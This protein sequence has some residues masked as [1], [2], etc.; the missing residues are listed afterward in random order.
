MASLFASVTSISSTQVNKALLTWQELLAESFKSR[1]F[2]LQ[3]FPASH[4][5]CWFRG[6]RTVGKWGG[7][8]DSQPAR[9]HLLLYLFSVLRVVMSNRWGSPCLVCSMHCVTAPHCS[10]WACLLSRRKQATYFRGRQ[11]PCRKDWSLRMSRC[12]PFFSV[13][14]KV[15]LLSE[16]KETKNF[17]KPLTFMRQFRQRR[18]LIFHTPLHFAIS[19][20]SAENSSAH[21][22]VFMRK[23]PMNI[24]KTL[25]FI[26]N[27]T[28]AN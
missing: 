11:N 13:Y 18:K 9:Q 27:Q 21:Y 8:I 25:L 7:G 20:P 26:R 16:Y 3:L 6:S 4:W 17:M 28:S 22:R 2:Q 15:V 12:L 14:W 19:K 5:S 10:C 24:W 1:D 23:W